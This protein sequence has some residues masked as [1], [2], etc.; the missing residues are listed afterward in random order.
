VTDV[1]TW[2]LLVLRLASGNQYT[3]GTPKGENHIAG[4]AQNWSESDTYIITF[5]LEF[6]IY[7]FHQCPTCQS[8]TSLH[9][10]QTTNH[11]QAAYI[12]PTTS[13]QLK[14]IGDKRVTVSLHPTLVLLHNLIQS[15]K[16]ICPSSTS[17]DSLHLLQYTNQIHLHYDALQKTAVFSHSASS[18]ATSSIWQ[19]LISQLKEALR[20]ED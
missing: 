3:R 13:N 12:G 19:N 7:I 20:E 8:F 17:L 1:P 15:P 9:Q 10:Q 14:L 11:H 16:C 18:I 6:S 5:P 2:V 4:K